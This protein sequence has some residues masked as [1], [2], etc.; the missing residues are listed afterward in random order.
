MI[1]TMSREARSHEDYTIG[2]ISGLPLEE[3]AVTAMLDDTHSPLQQHSGDLNSYTFGNMGGHNVVIT[4]L[5]SGLY[6][7]TAA[8]TVAERMKRSFPRIRFGLLVGIGG[9]VPNGSADLRLGDVVVS[10]PTGKYGGVIQYDFGK[11]IEGGVFQRT[12][13]L[14]KPPTILLSA[15]SKLRASHILG[16]NQIRAILNDTKLKYP[17]IVAYPGPDKDLLFDSKYDHFG[18]GDMCQ[19]CDRSRLVKRE[20]HQCPDN[21]PRVFYGLIASG[22][23]KMKHALTRDKFARELDVLCFE[24]EAAGLMDHFPCLV[25][26]GISDYADSHNPRQ[27]QTYAAA[28]ATAYAKELLH[29]IPR[30]RMPS[31]PLN[32]N[33]GRA[34]PFRQR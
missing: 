27:W 21:D 25:I 34:L 24:M 22:N 20:I 17:N 11:T 3:A 2:W 12:G 28:T 33:T 16:G 29:V 30:D 10:N 31:R 18:S 9:G 14:N 6:G 32:M 19:A 1:T 4:C 15:L 26:R 13:V 23:G 7:T 5:P 8:A